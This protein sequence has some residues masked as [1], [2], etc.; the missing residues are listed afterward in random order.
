MADKRDLATIQKEELEKFRIRIEQ[1]RRK[2][3]QYLLGHEKVE[4]TREREKLDIQLKKSKLMLTPYSVIRFR[5]QNLMAHYRTHTARWDRVQR[6]REL[7]LVREIRTGVISDGPT[8][9]EKPAAE[10]PVKEQSPEEKKAKAK[11]LSSTA[12]EA[13]ELASALTKPKKKPKADTLRTV[14]DDWVAAK[15][16]VG[17]DGAGVG[18]ERF[19]ARLEKQQQSAAKKGLD[20]T[21][22]VTVEKGKV[23]VTPKTNKKTSKE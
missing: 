20:L 16:Q 15:K 13:E 19:K 3:D 6:N 10:K 9:P 8:P 14:Y 4:P 23:T 11:R 2:Y 18:Y 1:L 5:F 17:Q 22:D 7:D 12:Q 21:F